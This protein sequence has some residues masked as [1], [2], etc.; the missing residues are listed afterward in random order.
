VILTLGR[1]APHAPYD[2]REEVVR[3]AQESGRTATIEYAMGPNIWMIKFS[4]H[5]H[6]ERLKLFREGR[7]AEEPKEVVLLIDQQG[8]PLDIHQMGPSGVRAFLER[9]NTW[10]GRGEYASVEE[11]VRE[12]YAKDRQDAESAREDARDG[13]IH[14]ARDR[15]RQYMGIPLIT[16]G[17]DLT[18]RKE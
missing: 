12:S 6:D 11:M 16:A 13:A 14:E 15:R 4:L 10:S 18:T 1:H 17:I 5:P 2:I 7:I 3:Y 9:G 8:R